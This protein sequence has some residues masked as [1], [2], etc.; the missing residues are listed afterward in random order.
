MTASTARHGKG[1]A[2]PSSISPLRTRCLANTRRPPGVDAGPSA[3]LVRWLQ[4]GLTR[5]NGGEGAHGR[6]SLSRV[7]FGPEP[8]RC[9][10]LA[11]IIIGGLLGAPQSLPSAAA[12]P[13]QSLGY[14]DRPAATGR[15]LLDLWQDREDRRHRIEGLFGAERATHAPPGIVTLRGGRGLTA[16]APLPVTGP[17]AQRRARYSPLVAEAARRHGVPAELVHAV[18]RAESAYNA[19][20]RSPAGARGLMQLMPATAERFGVRDIWHPAEN[21]DGGTRYLRW[22][23]ERFDGRLPLV[24]AGYNAGENAVERYGRAVPPFRETQEYVARV[25][26]YL[27]VRDA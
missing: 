4:A 12:D 24:L 6:R 20:A 2:P 25:L 8:V 17:L 15:Q 3:T 10:R 26:R 18:I 9:L 23:F 5:T 27:G 7:R 11:A 19:K 16:F 21:I 22:L 1:C 13:L 14:R